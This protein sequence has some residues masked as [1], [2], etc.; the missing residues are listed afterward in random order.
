MLRVPPIPVDLL[1]IAR[2]VEHHYLTSFAAA[3]ALVCPPTGALKIERRYAL[4]DAGAAAAEAGESR[5]RELDG[6]RLQAGPHAADA[7]RYRRKGWLRVAYRVHVVGVTAPGRTL[8]RGPE[9]PA[10]I[11]ARQRTALE[12]V[13]DGRPARRA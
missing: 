2:R 11:G 6:A 13:E 3:L 7:E 9:T 12:L 4:T 8:R 5:L 1:D 10:R